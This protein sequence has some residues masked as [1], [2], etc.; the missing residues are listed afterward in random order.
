PARISEKSVPGTDFGRHGF[1]YRLLRAA[2]ARQHGFDERAERGRDEE[3]AETLQPAREALPRVHDS[4]REA[5][6]ERE[7]GRADR[8]ED[9]RAYP[10]RR[11]RGDAL[12]GRGPQPHTACAGPRR[13]ARRDSSH[14]GAV[15]EHDRLSDGF[16]RDDVG[17]RRA[18]LSAA[19]KSCQ[20]RFFAKC[21]PGTNFR[22]RLAQRWNVAR[23]RYGEK[24]RISASTSSPVGRR[25]VSS[26]RCNAAASA[27]SPTGAESAKPTPRIST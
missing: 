11:G 10:A 14:V 22:Q 25:S 7:A 2:K 26:T 18:R 12:R 15:D 21:V 8:P 9:G 16:R 13:D 17:G 4:A 24:R 23:L 6:R 19:E 20:A 1:R 5:R 27:T 3:A